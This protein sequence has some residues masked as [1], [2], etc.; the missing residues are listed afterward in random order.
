MKKKTLEELRKDIEEQIPGVDIAPYSHNIIS[1]TLSAI[2]KSFSKEEANRAID[3][4]ALE[5]LGW[6]KE[7]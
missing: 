7:S 4:F 5:E 6:K 2:A 1:L 3:D